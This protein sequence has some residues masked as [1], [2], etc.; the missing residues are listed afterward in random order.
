M[1]LVSAHS[2]SKSRVSALEEATEPCRG[3]SVYSRAFLLPLMIKPSWR[4]LLHF[5]RQGL[6]SLE[7]ADPA[8]PAGQ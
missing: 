5:P 2:V 8:G 1:P 7:L 6:L 4:P 3:F